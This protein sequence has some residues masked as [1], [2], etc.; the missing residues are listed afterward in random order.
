VS[1]QDKSLEQLHAEVVAGLE[2]PSRTLADA[3]SLAALITQLE[4]GGA[5]DAADL[6]RT[7]KLRL[8]ADIAALRKRK[9]LREATRF[10]EGAFAMF[11]DSPALRKSLTELNLAAAEVAERTRDGEIMQARVDL[12][13]LL[14]AKRLDDAW[15]AA[16]EAQ[17]QRLAGLLS[18]DDPYLRKVGEQVAALYLTRAARLREDRRMTEAQRMQEKA[19]AHGVSAEAL[20]AEEHLFRQELLRLQADVA[21]RERVARLDA[22]KQR[23][24]TQAQAN[25]VPKATETLKELRTSLPKQDKFLVEEAP[26]AIARAYVRMASSAARD[27]RMRDAIKLVD[28]GRASAKTAADFTMLRNRYVRYAEIADEVISGPLSNAERICRDLV[29]FAAQDAE[30]EAEVARWLMKRLVA[31]INATQEVEFASRLSRAAQL[32][33]D[34]QAEL[35]NQS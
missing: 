14:D 30:E 17:L 26:A 25:E 9:G 2:A 8:T 3:R 15:P 28:R 35:G 11:P 33:A 4:R 29:A 31:R 6:R 27:G 32:L 1:P 18:P 22:L 20:A 23:F 10:A 19:R 12:A 21:E 7:L 13:A 34:Q 24:L 16:V 5:P